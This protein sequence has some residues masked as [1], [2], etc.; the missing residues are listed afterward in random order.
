M[1]IESFTLEDAEGRKIRGDYFQSVF[2]MSVIIHPENA[3]RIREGMALRARWE[4]V[5]DLGRKGS[6]SGEFK[7]Q[8]HEHHLSESG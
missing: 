7:L 2:N 4:V 1:K 8:R 6:G 3:G 5:D